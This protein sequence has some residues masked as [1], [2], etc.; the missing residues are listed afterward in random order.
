MG[1][2]VDVQAAFKALHPPSALAGSVVLHVSDP[3]CDWNDGL[4]TVTAEAGHITVART[5]TAPGITV[6]IQTLSQ[7]Y[8]GHPSLASL[9]DA[10]RMAVTDENQF[11]LIR[12]SRIP[13]FK[14]RRVA[15]ADK[16]QFNL[17]S[18]LLPAAIA[19]SADDF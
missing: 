5:D 4:F 9:R 3:Q 11:R 17:L 14:K 2:I 15:V 13:A 1:R 8:W 12:Y 18:A 7:A 19:F 16:S 10:G 6:D